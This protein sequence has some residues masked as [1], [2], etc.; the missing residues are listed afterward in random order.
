MDVA[1]FDYH[2]ASS[3]VGQLSQSL[4][5]QDPTRFDAV[6]DE[7]EILH[8]EEQM[9]LQEEEALVK[10]SF[11]RRMTSR[12]TPLEVSPSGRVFQSVQHSRQEFS[13]PTMS[14]VSHSVLWSSSPK[15]LPRR[16]VQSLMSWMHTAKSPPSPRK[17]T[18][19]ESPKEGRG[20]LR[21]PKSTG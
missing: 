14:I 20:A 17:L 12:A 3:G 2:A 13:K 19:S 16:P 5:S 15:P 1:E 18:S 6:D 8:V 11:S 10:H 9:Q 4:W 7:E 21:R